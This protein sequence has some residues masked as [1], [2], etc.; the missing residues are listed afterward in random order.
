MDLG[1][2]YMRSNEEEPYENMRK[3][4]EKILSLL[5]KDQKQS[6]LKLKAEPSRDISHLRDKLKKPTK[7][8]FQPL[9]TDLPSL[10]SLAKSSTPKAIK[11]A[12]PTSPS[13]PQSYQKKLYLEPISPQ[14]TPNNP[15]SKTTSYKLLSLSPTPII[16]KFPSIEKDLNSQNN[17]QEIKNLYKW[18]N[19]MKNQCEDEESNEIVYTICARELV[20][21]ITANSALRGK[22]LREI[23]KD[24]PFVFGEKYKNLLTEFEEYKKEQIPRIKQLKNELNDGICGRQIEVDIMKKEIVDKNFRVKKLENVVEDY[25]KTIEQVDR[26]MFYNDDLWKNRLMMVIDEVDYLKKKLADEESLIENLELKRFNSKDEASYEDRVQIKDFLLDIKIDEEVRVEKEPK[27]EI[28]ILIEEGVD[29][30]ID[31]LGKGNEENNERNEENKDEGNEKEGEDNSLCDDKV[32]NEGEILKDAEIKNDAFVEEIKKNP[33]IKAKKSKKRMKKVK[34]EDDKVVIENLEKFDI[35]KSDKVEKHNQTK[36]IFEK[37][38]E[39]STFCESKNHEKLPTLE[40]KLDIIPLENIEDPKSSDQIIITTST[41]NNQIIKNNQKPLK[42]IQIPTITTQSILSD[43][44]PC[45][46]PKKILN[47]QPS[48]IPSQT[49]KALKNISFSYTNDKIFEVPSI[50]EESIQ[51]LNP[52]LKTSKNHQ[53]Q[54]IQTE[55]FLFEK[56]LSKL[57]TI[58]EHIDK[59]NTEEIE[60]ICKNPK[61]QFI[62]NSINFNQQPIRKQ[63][64]RLSL[65]K[66]QKNLQRSFTVKQS[67]NTENITVNKAVNNEEIVCEENDKG[68]V[69]EGKEEVMAF[70]NSVSFLTSKITQKKQEILD[71]DKEI[72]EKAKV[73]AIINDKRKSVKK[74]GQKNIDVNRR[75]TMLK[76]EKQVSDDKKRLDKQNT[77]L[78]P[79][80]KKMGTETFINDNDISPWD[81]GYEVGY[82]DGKINGLLKAIEEIKNNKKSGYKLKKNYDSSSLQTL[83]RKNDK[84]RASTKNIDPN[85]FSATK[86]K[87]RKTLTSP[88]FIESTRASIIQNKN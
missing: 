17:I 24:Q 50:D 30:R 76:V 36:N 71:L 67:Q 31:E 29:E 41:P 44:F 22:L 61:N 58:E 74:K 8:S 87:P 37:L 73:L 65:K 26:K 9:P 56:Y 43:S 66:N 60:N 27:D 78:S 68:I 39:K 45:I 32:E 48:P 35:E 77:S 80:I 79:R 20:K 52:T 33:V 63:G 25:K 82:G 7:K 38:A 84:P 59:A 75:M 40:N 13:S 15:Q 85:I 23:I 83:K 51:I 81:E 11:I 47:S 12:L 69:D 28:P 4:E 49:V 42:P 72:S 14:T 70:I 88:S 57:R 2:L 1:E 54:E 21:Q 53:C 86:N 10:K 5:K 3:T 16:E 64:K 6:K 18:F 46:S 55:D 19:T 62:E 34:K